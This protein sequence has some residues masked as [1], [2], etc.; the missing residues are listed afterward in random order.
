MNRRVVSCDYLLLRANDRS[1]EAATLM[2]ALFHAS[3]IHMLCG[4]YTVANKETDEFA[5]LAD[6]KTAAQWKAQA[7][8]VVTGRHADALQ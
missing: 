7:G 6:E 8:L 4:D 5:A 3:L 2:F 1:S